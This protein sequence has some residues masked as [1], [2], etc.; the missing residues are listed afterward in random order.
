MDVPHQ[1]LEHLVGFLLVLHQ[2]VLLAVGAVLNG[3]S[4]QVEIVEVVLPFLVDDG[5]RHLRQHLLVHVRDADSLPELVEVLDLAMKRGFAFGDRGLDHR[6]Q[7]RR[8]RSIGEGF[9]RH[10]ELQGERVDQPLAIP[11]FRTLGLLQEL[12]HRML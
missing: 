3:V 5:E 4:Q 1:V 6:G 12:A 2:R 11:I 7:I 8:E 9:R 10:Q